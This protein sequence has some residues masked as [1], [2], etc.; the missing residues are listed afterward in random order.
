MPPG[1]SHNVHETCGGVVMHVSPAYTVNSILQSQ[2]LIRVIS[3][4]P[5]KISGLQVGCAYVTVTYKKENIKV[6]ILDVYLFVIFV[7][8]NG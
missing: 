6:R 7:E 2:L 8:I 3:Q 4:S 5:G 1:P